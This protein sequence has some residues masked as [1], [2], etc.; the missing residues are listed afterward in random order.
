MT[1]LL[2]HPRRESGQKAR[3]QHKLEIHGGEIGRKQHP[4]FPGQLGEANG[5]LPGPAMIGRE[6]CHE[7]IEPDPEAGQPAIP[8]GQGDEPQIK[9]PSK[10]CFS[11]RLM[12]ELDQRHM[13]RRSS[14]PESPHDGGEGKP[15][16][17]IDVPHPQPA[18]FAPGSAA[19][20]FD[21][22]A[23]SLEG[24]TRFSQKQ[25]S[26]LGERDFSLG[27]VK[28][29]NPELLLE[30]LDLLTQGGLGQVETGGG[31]AEVELL[32]EGDE[33]AKVAELHSNKNNLL[34]NQNKVL[35]DIS[36]LPYCGDEIP[37]P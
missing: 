1:R 18:Y 36:S 28:Q 5:A 33:V 35:A 23:G 11:L 30:L 29:E 12:M 15:G 26:R 16:C 27:P 6:G 10:D 7:G 17:Q 25:P 32:G 37:E 9:I 21:R 31:P 24:P 13:N 4:V 3:S 19:G 2:H 8:L 22:L 34:I 14:L 20:G